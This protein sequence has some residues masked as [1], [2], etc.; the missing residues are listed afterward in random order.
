MTYLAVFKNKFILTFLASVY[1]VYVYLKCVSWLYATLY[2]YFI[3][4]RLCS[5]EDHGE[6]VN[7]ACC[8]T[9][10]LS[11]GRTDLIILQSV[12]LSFDKLDYYGT[13][14]NTRKRR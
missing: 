2:Y 7:Y 10:I 4:M 13:V 3:I 5:T 12:Y 9:Q 1:I 14:W 11:F 8:D 6:T